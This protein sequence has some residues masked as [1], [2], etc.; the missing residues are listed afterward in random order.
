[1][2]LFA[3]T[4]T[5]K[6][7][8]ST[9]TGLGFLGTLRAGLA[10]A[11]NN[12]FATLLSA[13]ENA[14][15]PPKADL[16][17]LPEP[18]K[19]VSDASSSQPVRTDNSNVVRAQEPAAPKETPV[20]A[21]ENGPAKTAKA[22]DDDKDDKISSDEDARKAEQNAK[23]TSE[24]EAK[25]EPDADAMPDTAQAQEP[26]KSDKTQKTDDDALMALWIAVPKAPQEAKPAGA[27]AAPQ[28]ADGADEESA[29][30]SVE[31]TD[32]NEAETLAALMGFPQ[33]ASASR[34]G[35]AAG[36][37]HASSTA[38]AASA[39]NVLT[40]EGPKASAASWIGAKSSTIQN[41]TPQTKN[42]NAATPFEKIQAQSATS[43]DGNA[44]AQ[45]AS[46][47]ENRT[48][49]QD[50]FAPRVAMP[51]T[52]GQAQAAMDQA[53]AQAA[54]QAASQIGAA[55][56][57]TAA[58][59]SANTGASANVTPT[60]GDVGRAGNGY[61]L[62]A[63]AASTQAAR[64][65]T[66]ATA[67]IV[68]QITVQMSKMVK[69]GKDEMTIHLRPEELGKIEIK[70]EFSSDKKVQG[71]IIADKAS[72][73]DLLQKDADTLQRTLQDAGLQA[74]AG[75]LQFSLRGDGQNNASAQ[76]G[77]N[78][79]FTSYAAAPAAEEA[80][81]LSPVDQ[82]IYYITPERVNLRV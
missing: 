8:H 29:T 61:G 47:A 74:D 48:T 78:G 13:V 81:A 67:Q 52:D 41:A 22:K 71:T 5:Q 34:A 51:V 10:G 77:T 69:E 4:G 11:K 65:Q 58:P 37:S 9:A 38:Q 63:Q 30:E 36:K 64:P 15:P 45:T 50:L 66:S 27:A 75:S 23:E 18:A 17:V 40:Q 3:D 56:T 31:G 28:E 20:A 14:L 16:P 42:E 44:T 80:S 62:T 24:P 55:A 32:E 2:A 12:G 49:L 70:L 76:N 39:E 79:A 54:A 7:T 1:M 43:G 60:I 59:A 73:L 21:N 25:K 82:E 57:E 72:T 53:L 35:N 19:P 46:V 68:E 6:T 26:V 33:E